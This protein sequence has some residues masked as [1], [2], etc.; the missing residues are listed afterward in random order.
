MKVSACTFIRNG[1]ILG[2]PFVESIRSVLP[3]VDEFVIAVGVSE[4]ETL[5]VLRGLQVEEPKIRLLET[6]WNETMQVRGYVY[7][8][9]KMIAQFACSGEW[10]FYLE[11]DEVVHEGDLGKIRASMEQ[12]RHDD[13]V[14]ALVFDYLHFYGN[15]NTYLWSPGWYRRAPRIIK[16]SVRSYAPDGLFWLIL[17][18]NKRGRYP[19][20]AHVGATMYHYG[21]V[22][23]EAQMNVKAS[24]VG[25][26]W[27]KQNDAIDY[28]QMDGS[29][30]REFTG[31]HPAVMQGYLPGEA[32]LFQVDP[33]YRPTRKQR[34]HRWMLKL[35]QWF[36]LEL[37]RKHYKLARK[38]E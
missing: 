20:A 34:R 27:N 11:A 32:G 10:I 14:E 5:A 36:G 2:Y 18:S 3:I 38:P 12:Y 8:Q 7:G 17:E 30:L 13:A 16:A 35:E 4:D 24:K 9:Q 28:R 19:Y 1:C 26:Y 22:R 25:K 6:T 33:A 37:S 23:S 21:W 15:A 29:I 31:T